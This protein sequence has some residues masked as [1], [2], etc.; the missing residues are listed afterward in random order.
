MNAQKLFPF[1]LIV[2]VAILVSSA[3]IFRPSFLYQ[4]NVVETSAPEVVVQDFYEWYLS[5]QGNPLVDQA[6]QGT[7]FLTADFVASLDEFVEQG[8][9]YDPVLCAQDKPQEITPG[10]VD[11]SGNEATLPVTTSFEGHEFEVK[12]SLVDGDWKIDHVICDQ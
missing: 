8:M 3:I 1:V 12:L 10:E 4:N 2:G 9:Q 5:Y 6:Y 11:I 7:R